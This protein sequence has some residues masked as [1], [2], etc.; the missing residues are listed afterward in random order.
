MQIISTVWSLITITGLVVFE[1]FC[2]VTVTLMLLVA[3]GMTIDECKASYA[4]LSDSSKKITS[5][6]MNL[7]RSIRKP[8]VKRKGKRNEHDV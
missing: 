6:A 1:V 5:G 8:N 3:L 4:T 7:I 2:V